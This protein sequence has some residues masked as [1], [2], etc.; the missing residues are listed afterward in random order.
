[1]RQR[2]GSDNPSSQPELSPTGRP[3]WRGEWHAAIAQMT[4]AL[5][6]RSAAWLCVALLWFVAFLNYLD[7]TVIFSMHDSVTHAIPMTEAQYGE[8][9]TVFL[10]ACG[11]LSPFGGF[12]A[13]RLGRRRVIVG[14]LFAWSVITWLTG[15]ARTFDQLLLARGAMGLSE[16]CYIP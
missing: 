12:L 14:S 1:G 15:Q 4:S 11:A 2:I 10:W 7:R 8:L 3:H 6:T 16:A 5:P 13:D 9:T